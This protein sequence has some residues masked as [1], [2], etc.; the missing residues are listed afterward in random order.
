MVDIEKDAN[1]Q[2]RKIATQGMTLVQINDLNTAQ[3]KP[4][5]HDTLKITKASLRHK[6]CRQSRRSNTLKKLHVL[7]WG[8]TALPF[9]K[10]ERDH[11]FPGDFSR[12]CVQNA[13]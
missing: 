13:A 10:Q 1:K 4:W 7:D 11:V 2:A 12:F 9:M 6:N 3:V 8:H 5:A